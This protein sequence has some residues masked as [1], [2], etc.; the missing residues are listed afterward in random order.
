MIAKSA[1]TPTVA[2]T[3]AEIVFLSLLS[4][5]DAVE[6]GESE[7]GFAVVAVEVDVELVDVEREVVE[8]AGVDGEGDKGPPEG[9]FVLNIG[10]VK[11][12]ELH[13]AKG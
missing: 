2:P 10:F 1:I 3:A 4:L 11:R 5:S 8:E 7:D 6:T 9:K 12:K 13:V